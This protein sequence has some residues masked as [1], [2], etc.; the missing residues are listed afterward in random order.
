MLLN[1]NFSHQHELND[2]VTMFRLL[3]NTVYVDNSVYTIVSSNLWCLRYYHGLV[4]H[5][6]R[7]VLYCQIMSMECRFISC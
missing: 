7:P 5:P 6:K 2:F 3:I 4:L 1:I